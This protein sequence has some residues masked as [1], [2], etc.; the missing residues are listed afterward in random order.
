MATH[1]LPIMNAS[2]APDSSG[3]IFPTPLEVALT[4]ATAALG[5]DQCFTMLAPTGSD[6]GFNGH[7]KRPKVYVGSPV[8]VIRGILAE[9]ANT[10]AFGFQQF[11]AGHSGSIDTAYET[12]DLVNNATWTGLAVNDEFEA[13]ITITPGSGYSDGGMIYWSFYRDDSVDS[14]TGDFHLTGL[15]F[16]YN[17]A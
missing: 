6:I 10:L 5:S 16:R 1:D 17:D 9:A 14:Q 4:L 2:F 15:F 13:L 8:L 3:D 11:E 7:F 12:E